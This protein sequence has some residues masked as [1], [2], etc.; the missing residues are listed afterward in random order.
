[1]NVG[2]TFSLLAFILVHFT[3]RTV[4]V[5]TVATFKQLD[6][7]GEDR[8][9]LKWKWGPT[10]VKM[11]HSKNE[12]GATLSWSKAHRNV[13][14]S[15]SAFK[16][17]LHL[18]LVISNQPEN[19]VLSYQ[20]KIFHGVSILNPFFWRSIKV[21][22]TAS[23]YHVC[24]HACIEPSVAADRITHSIGWCKWVTTLTS[25]GSSLLFLACPSW[26][27]IGVCDCLL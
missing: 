2:I 25:E 15:D 14:G 23:H 19:N 27:N 7:E 11:S 1:M 24:R 9:E 8:A 12:N 3:L 10:K 5:S 6:H 4:P 16:M 17:K 13:W 26:T 21:M 20:N 18:W 22:W